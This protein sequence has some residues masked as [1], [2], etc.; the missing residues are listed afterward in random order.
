MGNKMGFDM[1][2]EKGMNEFTLYYNMHIAGKN[3]GCQDEKED[4]IDNLPAIPAQSQFTKKKKK[5]KK[6]FKQRQSKKKK[7]KKKR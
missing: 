3:L 7:K 4:A 5:R 2:S 1:T 6:V